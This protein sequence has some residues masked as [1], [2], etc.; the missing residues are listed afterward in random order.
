MKKCC[1]CKL[2]K[3]F[4]DFNKN[5]RQIDGYAN[6]CKICRKNYR[7]KNIEKIV[8]YRN[9]YKNITTI[10][11][12]KSKTNSKYFREKYQNDE[13]F[14]LKHLIR[15]SIRKSLNKKGYTKKSKTFE[16]LGCDYEFFKEYIENQFNKNMNWKNIH[17]DHIM[18]ISSAK[19]KKEVIL[20]NHYTNFQPLLIKDNLIKS[21]K[22]IEK[23]L[24]L[25]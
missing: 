11:S 10:K 21:N 18:P 13:L 6:Q 1:T 9:I 4:S 24:K 16:I 22:I 15:T 5:K 2:E 3:T 14:K 19:S 20:L 25:L 12:K 17:L 23:Q 7:L 8:E